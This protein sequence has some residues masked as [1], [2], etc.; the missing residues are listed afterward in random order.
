MLQ[1]FTSLKYHNDLILQCLQLSYQWLLYRVLGNE[2]KILLLYSNYTYTG[3]LFTS[4]AA[5]PAETE[6]GMRKMS[7]TL[8]T[9]Q[10]GAKSTLG[11]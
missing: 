10:A 5:M 2:P 6:F 1:F 7:A 11:Y 8:K 9:G 3:E 4:R